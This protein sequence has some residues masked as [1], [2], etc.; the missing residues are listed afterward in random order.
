MWA[1]GIT[2]LPKPN[3]NQ[4]SNKLFILFSHIINQFPDAAQSLPRKKYQR[5][6]WANGNLIS[7]QTLCCMRSGLFNWMITYSIVVAF[8]SVFFSLPKIFSKTLSELM[9]ARQ[10]EMY[11]KILMGIAPWGNYLNL[12]TSSIQTIIK[13]IYIF[14][15]PQIQWQHSSS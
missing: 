3:Y 5:P 2:H 1:H 8:F 6:A 11:V 10:H 4:D 13:E 7:V 12:S 9:Y 15:R 14:V